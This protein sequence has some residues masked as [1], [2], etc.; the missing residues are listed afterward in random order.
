MNNQRIPITR[1]PYQ[2]TGQPHVTPPQP[3]HHWCKAGPPIHNNSKALHLQQMILSTPKIRNNNAVNQQIATTL[4]AQAPNKLS[5]ADCVAFL[6][7]A[8]LPL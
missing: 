6:H 5:P 4:V 3:R 7:R 1:P 8:S 2:P